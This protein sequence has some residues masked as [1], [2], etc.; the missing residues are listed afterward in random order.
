MGTRKQKFAVGTKFTKR[1]D[2][3]KKIYTV[4]DFLTTVNLKGKIVKT[5]YIASNEL[6]SQKVFDYDVVETTIAMGEIKQK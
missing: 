2:K 4:E 1:S 3:H 5:C 6:C